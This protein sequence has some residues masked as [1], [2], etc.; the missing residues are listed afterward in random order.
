MSL[1][2]L[3]VSSRIVALLALL[4]STQFINGRVWAQRSP[5]LPQTNHQAK[6]PPGPHIITLS[7]PLIRLSGSGLPAEVLDLTAGK[8]EKACF[9]YQVL[10]TNVPNRV[11]LGTRYTLSGART[12]LKQSSAY[13]LSSSAGE[14]PIADR[15]TALTLLLTMH[16]GGESDLTFALFEEI[17]ASSPENEP[18][19]GRQLSNPFRISVRVHTGSPREIENAAYTQLMHAS[20]T[21]ADPDLYCRVFNCLVPT[22]RGPFKMMAP[23]LRY[24][25]SLQ[26]FHFLAQVHKTKDELSRLFGK[27]DR[28]D[29][30]SEKFAASEKKQV[31]G[32]CWVYGPLT[33]MFQ[34]DKATYVWLLG[35]ALQNVDEYVRREAEQQ[36]S[37]VMK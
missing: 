27:P 21:S 4:N 17:P 14:I 30:A 36:Q 34:E 26:Y 37:K 20:E 6:Q 9:K 1:Q 29:I 25:D 16:G 22:L 31:T 15:L 5:D 7:D 2:P 11:L 23:G 19:Y 32:D 10:G 8:F 35:P 24:P 18:G 12:W 3:I 28:I 13:V 33:I